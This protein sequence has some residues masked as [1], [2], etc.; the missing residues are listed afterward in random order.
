MSF[1]K[2]ILGAQLLSVPGLLFSNSV[3]A[4]SLEAVP[5]AAETD[6]IETIVITADPFARTAD[7]LTQPSEILAGEALDRKRGL[8]L[9]ETLEN[10]L[11]VSSTDFGRGAGRPVIRGQGGP[12]VLNLHNGMSAGDVSDVSSDHSVSIDPAQAEQIEILK[13]PATL[14]YGS[15]AAAGVVNV[16]DQ[17]LPAQAEEGLRARIGASYASVADQ[18]AASGRIEYGIGQTLFNVDAAWRDADDYRI[19][20]APSD[21]L[22]NSAVRTASGS[23]SVAQFGAMGSIAARYGR[24]DSRYGLP[25]EETAFIDLEQS[26]RDIEARL[27]RPISG[28]ESLRLRYGSSQ[29]EHIEFEDA[30]EPGTRF[31]NDQ[32][33]ARLE[34]LHEPFADFR[35]VI[36]VHRRDRDFAALGDEAFLPPSRSRGLGVF[37]VE[38][39]PTS[40][41]SIELGF[42]SDE[43]RISSQGQAPVSRRFRPLTWSGGVSWE[44]DQKHH[45]KFY[46]TRS[47]RSPVAEELF[48]FGPHLASSSFERGDRNLELE[49]SQ[50]FELA[51][52][53]HG[54]VWDWRVN[55]FHQRIA[56]YIYQKEV[57][58]GLNA[59]GTGVMLA[60]GVADRV[61]EDGTLTP[62]GEFLLLDYRS[63]NARFWGAEA[64]VSRNWSIGLT[65]VQTRIFADWVRGRIIDQENLPRITPARW[66]MAVHAHRGPLSASLDWIAV[67]KQD[68]VAALESETDGYEMLSARAEYAFALRYG[69][70]S[71]F[72]AGHNLLDQEARR[73]TSLIKDTAP[74]PGISVHSGFEWRI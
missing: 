39:R 25:N 63:G 71:L 12:R 33:E 29:Y 47:Q 46:A 6:P 9:G 5:A 57:D 35:G 42:R 62:Q 50:N 31:T 45:L 8:S 34:L 61:D 32:K 15:G 2:R 18:P 11:G 67:Q 17:S 24:F 59:D 3:Y 28:L 68:H 58:A 10:E 48:S 23:A 51:L 40:F 27:N 21:E 1:Y 13:G 4:A 38:H 26:R 55:V 36:G 19:P 74:L 22:E 20:D 65:Q 30:G 66:G 44:L 52:D 70:L 14:I 7:Q 41:G 72:L 54:E 60:D 56:D 43:D 73:H 69:S 64:E 37:V 16:V 49:T 53:R